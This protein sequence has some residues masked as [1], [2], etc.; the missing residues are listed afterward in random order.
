MNKYLLSLFMPS[1]RFFW[2]IRGLVSNFFFWGL[3][4]T[5]FFFFFF[6]SSLLIFGVEFFVFVVTILRSGSLCRTIFSSFL[7]LSVLLYFF[8]LSV[9][10]FV[11]GPCVDILFSTLGVPHFFS[12]PW[13]WVFFFNVPFTFTLSLTWTIVQNWFLWVLVRF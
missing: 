2:F 13:S 11:L 6:F 12:C 3:C 8:F 1:S 7:G 10:C 5:F 9:V 4:R